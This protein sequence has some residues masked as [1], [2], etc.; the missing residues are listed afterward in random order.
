MCFYLQTVEQNRQKLILRPDIET[1]GLIIIRV[2]FIYHGFYKN[3]MLL[4]V[5]NDGNMY[6]VEEEYNI[7]LWFVCVLFQPTPHGVTTAGHG[8]H[9]YL[10]MY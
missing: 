9:I 6:V 2:L 3:L 1:E 10:L 5:T 7:S 4:Q 8:L